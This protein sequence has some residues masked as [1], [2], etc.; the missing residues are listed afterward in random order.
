V[1][2][3][4]FFGGRIVACRSELRKQKRVACEQADQLEFIR[5]AY[6]RDYHVQ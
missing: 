4:E 1:C 6:P 3:E 5:G 2:D